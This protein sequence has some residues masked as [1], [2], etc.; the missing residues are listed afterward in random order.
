MRNEAESDS[1]ALGLASLPYR[2]SLD[3]R[4]LRPRAPRTGPLRLSGYPRTLDRGYML[5]EQFTW[6]TPH[7]QLERARLTWHTRERREAEG[8]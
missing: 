3:L 8:A 7:S 6:L 2:R 5:N 1:L 4:A